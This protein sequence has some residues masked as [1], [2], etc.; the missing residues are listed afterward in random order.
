MAITILLFALCSVGTNSKLIGRFGRSSI[1]PK[2]GVGL[3]GST[4]RGDCA[5]QFCLVSGEFD[6]VA[7]LSGLGQAF[8]CRHHSA[9][10]R[11]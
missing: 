1:H 4:G 6:S 10:L 7:A 3:A 9:T 2:S 11:N 5:L 8:S